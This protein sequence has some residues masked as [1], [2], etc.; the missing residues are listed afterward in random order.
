MIGKDSA[1]GN[2]KYILTEVTPC[3]TNCLLYPS[4]PNYIARMQQHFIFGMFNSGLL[5][6]KSE[7]KN[8]DKPFTN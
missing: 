5:N 8:Y 7:L 3:V 6:S 2:K 4:D 1:T